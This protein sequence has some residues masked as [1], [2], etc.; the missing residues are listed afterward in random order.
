M[1]AKTFKS[2][3]AA[4]NLPSASNFK[5]TYV[6]HVYDDIIPVFLDPYGIPLNFNNNGSATFKSPMIENS[7][8][9]FRQPD[10]V[11]HHC[12]GHYPN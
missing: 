2:A 8:C 3:S 5:K 4:F 9:A 10:M 12:V 7:V 6:F 1:S 11:L